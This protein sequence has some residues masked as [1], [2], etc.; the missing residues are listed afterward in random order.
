[1]ECPLGTNFKT[2]GS[3]DTTTFR[4]SLLVFHQ[5]KTAGLATCRFF[6]FISFIAGF[7]HCIIFI[8]TL[9]NN[10]YCTRVTV[11][12]HEEAVS[13]HIHL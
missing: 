3:A 11:L 1:M 7:K 10:I 4:F 5:R 12:E 9:V 13:Q 6:F 2:V 8:C